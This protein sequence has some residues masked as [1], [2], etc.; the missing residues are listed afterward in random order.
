MNA[1]P[2][3]RVYAGFAGFILVV[4]N[5]VVWTEI[6]QGNVLRVTFFSVGQ[7]DVYPPEVLTQEGDSQR[8]YIMKDIEFEEII[9]LT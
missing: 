1:L 5:L 3:H 7:G 8:M 9:T 2:K 6:A 4:V